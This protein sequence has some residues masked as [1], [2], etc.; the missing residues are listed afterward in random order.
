MKKTSVLLCFI[1]IFST[2][3][4]FNVYAEHIGSD[5]WTGTGTQL[6]P[7]VISDFQGLCDLRDNVNEQ[8]QTY[9]GVYFILNADILRTN[10]DNEL[11]F[12]RGIGCKG[13]YNS[14][15]SD[16]VF[17]GNFDGQGHT[18]DVSTYSN[19]NNSNCGMFGYTDGATIKNIIAST[20]E[21]ITSE[22]YS[23]ANSCQF[24][25][26]IVGYAVNTT[27][28]GCTNYEII[29]S[30]QQW[31]SF[32]GIVGYAEKSTVQN[33]TNYASFDVK[34]NNSSSA[35]GIAGKIKDTD[36]IEC[37]NFGAVTSKEHMG[38]IVG[39]A[40][41]TEL[42]TN[43]I[44][45]CVNNASFEAA[46]GNAG[47][48]VGRGDKIT[49]A[50]CEN[51]AAV[52][53]TANA[54]GGIAGNFSNGTIQNCTN[55]GTV[56][57]AGTNTGGILGTSSNCTYYDLTNNAAIH[58]TKQSVGGIAGSASGTALHLVNNGKVSIETT[59]TPQNCGGIVGILNG[60]NWGQGNTYLYESV[61]YGTVTGMAASVDSKLA[62]GG[63]AGQVNSH[64]TNIIDCVNYGTSN[65]A[66]IVGSINTNCNVKS[67]MNLGSS[68]Y[69]GNYYASG[70][71]GYESYYVEDM[72]YNGEP[73]EATG[74]NSGKT[75]TAKTATQLADSSMIETLNSGT[76]HYNG[77]ST[78]WVQGAKYPE[79]AYFYEVPAVTTSAQIVSIT[80]GTVEYKVTLSESV[81]SAIVLIALY[82]G[83]SLTAVKT[84][85]ASETSCV[86]D[87]GI[88]ADTAKIFVWESLANAKPLAVS[89]AKPIQ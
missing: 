71:V 49:I 76:D 13:A 78:V 38:G 77:S 65:A 25:G 68:P 20:P 56:T 87:S 83:E 74:P 84:V 43:K 75:A 70:S 4:C 88:Q 18:I 69:A 5:N 36:I 64:H 21:N 12:G 63:I 24:A 50:N 52:S 48:I 86:F 31:D 58:S 72:T 17:K 57:G 14:T 6:D 55:N 61:N 89:D 9:E 73:T 42:G 37:N 47:G 16:P 28:T 8:G 82:S 40:T 30:S 80:D 34:K 15:I 11:N 67:S 33:C 23:K 85:S 41:A 19:G 32:G 44:E 59:S 3:M 29:V 10:P 66:G 7:Y 2:F 46:G 54:V 35:G 62:A 45:K 81:Q 22:K 53:S 60:Y 27:I 51:T 39:Y 1:M 26:G 79:L